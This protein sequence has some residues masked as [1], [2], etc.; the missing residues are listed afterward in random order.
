MRRKARDR[1]GAEESWPDLMA[2]TPVGQGTALT[3]KEMTM[4]DPD[5]I[6]GK[7]RKEVGKASFELVVDRNEVK[8]RFRRREGFAREREGRRLREAVRFLLETR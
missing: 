7:A 1:T 2:P 3:G 8:D 6:K 4:R 5:T